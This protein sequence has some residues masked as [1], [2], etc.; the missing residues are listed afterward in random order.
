[1]LDNKT[2]EK[3]NRGRPSEYKEEY[4]DKVDEY[5]EAN[6][7]EEIQLVKQ[8]NSEKGYE[9]YDNKLKVKL[10]TIEGFAHFIGV[11]KKTLYNWRDEHE[12][13]LHALEKIEVEQKER[14]INSGLSNDYN[15]TIAKLILSSNHGMREKSDVTTDGEKI[16]D[17]S[18]ELTDK[19][20]R[21]FLD[22][23]N[24]GNNTKREQ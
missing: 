8:S 3:S 16:T 12:D 6:Q 14:L 15:S 20:L 18:K 23:N 9:M 17:E 24:K 2:E 13:F 11:S 4:I 10:P 1:M 7:D 19:A 22:E 21:Y 5:L